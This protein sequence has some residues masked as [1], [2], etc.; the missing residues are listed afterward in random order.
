MEA[1]SLRSGWVFTGR[2]RFRVCGV[3][4]AYLLQERGEVLSSCGGSYE[5]VLDLGHDLG[6]FA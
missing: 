6:G 2:E 5:L 3:G 1:W 4:R